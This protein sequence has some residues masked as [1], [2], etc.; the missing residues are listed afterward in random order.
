MSGIARGDV[1]CAD[2]VLHQMKHQLIRMDAVPGG[3]SVADEG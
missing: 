1:A 3:A 2:A